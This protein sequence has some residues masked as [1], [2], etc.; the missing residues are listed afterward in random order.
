MWSMAV[1]AAVYFTNDAVLILGVFGDF[2]DVL[3]A[4]IAQEGSKVLD[5]L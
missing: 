3:V 5:H 4:G 1:C 2:L